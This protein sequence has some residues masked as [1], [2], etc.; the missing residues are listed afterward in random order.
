M[1]VKYCKTLD[2][3]ADYFSI[4]KYIKFPFIAQLKYCKNQGTLMLTSFFI[5]GEHPQIV[6]WFFN[7]F[8][9]GNQ[10]KVKL[11]NHKFSKIGDGP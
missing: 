8:F 6:A 4:S 7:V 2:F 5:R 10:L 3:E 11:A 1:Q 9:K